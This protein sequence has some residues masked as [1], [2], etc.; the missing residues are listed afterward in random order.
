MRLTSHVPQS[1]QDLGAK[2]NEGVYKEVRQ[3]LL[4]VEMSKGR[5]YIYF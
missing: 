2:I 5:I 3:W 4:F 1:I